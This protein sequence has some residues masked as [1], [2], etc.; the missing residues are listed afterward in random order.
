MQAAWSGVHPSPKLA[1]SLPPCCVQAF[2]A[3]LLP[4]CFCL[5]GDTAELYFS[6]TMAL[7]AQSV[8]KM[9]P[10]FAGGG[11]RG[12]C[13]LPEHVCVPA[14]HALRT[15]GR[16]IRCMLR[17]LRALPLALAGLQ[18]RSWPWATARPT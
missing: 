10:R 2:V 4:L 14:V 9:R 15:G 11:P 13:G 3:A 6:P 8:P 5:L 18:S 12:S 17:Q 7:V 16:T 1:E